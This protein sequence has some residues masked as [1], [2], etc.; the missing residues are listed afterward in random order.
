MKKCNDPNCGTWNK[1]D[2][3]YCKKCGQKFENVS[4]GE[5]IWL[6]ILSVGGLLLGGYLFYLALTTDSSNDKT[7]LKYMSIAIMSL[8]GYGLSKL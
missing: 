5:K 3:R 2:A 7:L 4:E 8:S 1:N 6:G